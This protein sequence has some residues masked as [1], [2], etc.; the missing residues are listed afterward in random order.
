MEEDVTNEPLFPHFDPTKDLS[1]ANKNRTKRGLGAW[2]LTCCWLRN[3]LTAA[4]PRCDPA[5]DNR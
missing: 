3:E 5:A 2:S 4:F 1:Q